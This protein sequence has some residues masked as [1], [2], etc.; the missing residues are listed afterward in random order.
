MD[1]ETVAGAVARFISKHKSVLYSVSHNQSKVLELG[2]TVAVSEHYRSNGYAI[3]VV[4]PRKNSN[5]FLVKTSTR[6]APWN[7]THIVVAKGAS[8]FEIHMNLMV[9][10]AHD[11]G[12]YCVDVGIANAERIPSRA[13]RR[14]W[15][16]LDNCD[17]VTF[18][19]VKKLVVYPMLLAQF[20]GIVHEIKPEFMGGRLLRTFSKARHLTPA[21]VT[22]G[23][24]SGNSRQIVASYKRRRIRVTITENFDMRLANLRGGR[25]ATPF[26]SGDLES[27]FISIPENDETPSTGGDNADSIPENRPVSRDSGT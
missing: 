18:A 3:S 22:L 8:L 12:I 5:T 1:T 26:Y 15:R 25:Y 7:F 24:F 10:S 4:N 11:Q 2:A 19:E 20:I 16:C 17:L 9:R 13:G 6:G 21:L 23:N 27:E 14:K